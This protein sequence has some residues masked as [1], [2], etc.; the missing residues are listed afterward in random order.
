[1]RI[2]RAARAV[3][4][5]LVALGGGDRLAELEQAPVHRVADDRALAGQVVDVPNE[6]ESMLTKNV[7]SRSSCLRCARDVA[8]H[9][10][11]LHSSAPGRTTQTSRFCGRLGVERGRGGEDRGDAGGVVVGAG[12][13]VRERDVDQQHEA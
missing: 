12:D 11:A 9:A 7:F 8:R 10:L 3:A 5:R 1:M 13:D 6:T 4:A 2:G